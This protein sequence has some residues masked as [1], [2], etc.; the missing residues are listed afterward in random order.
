MRLARVAD[1]VSCGDTELLHT[2]LESVSV[3]RAD[4]FSEHNRA[5]STLVI[6]TARDILNSVREVIVNELDL[7]RVL[8]KR[9]GEIYQRSDCLFKIILRVL[10]FVCRTVE[11]HRKRGDDAA[12]VHIIGKR[13]VNPKQLGVVVINAVDDVCDIG[14]AHGHAYIYRLHAVVECGVSYV[15]FVV[16]DVEKAQMI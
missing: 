14:R 3:A 16:I 9:R 5:V 13:A 10:E 4:G 12:S 6:R 8:G 15:L 11:V 7:L 1:N 2:I